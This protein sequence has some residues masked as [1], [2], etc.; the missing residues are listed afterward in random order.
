[1]DEPEKYSEYAPATD[2]L[3]GPC[4]LPIGVDQLDADAVREVSPGDHVV[5]QV[6]IIECLWMNARVLRDGGD[7]VRVL[8]LDDAE[9]IG[10]VYT[11]IPRECLAGKVTEQ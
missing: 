9:G 7:Q 1:M 6:R 4:P 10:P 2:A 3:S 8:L 11:D 5:F